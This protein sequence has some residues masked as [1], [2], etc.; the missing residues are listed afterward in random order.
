MN[1]SD[2]TSRINTLVRGPTPDEMFAWKINDRFNAGIPDAFY[3]GPAGFLWVEYKL[4]KRKTLPKLLVPTLSA[5]QR[6]RLR[7][8]AT[9]Q[10]GT[11]F[12]VV[13]VQT[14]PRTTQLF[15]FSTPD[16]WENG[17]DARSVGA[18]SLADWAM[19]VRSICLTK[20]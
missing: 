5:Q 3:E 6:V 15:V 11:V 18:F 9:L 2:M 12:V 13:G 7:H 17:Y 4:V 16:D 8:L 1:E 14:A 19:K 20:R 10:P